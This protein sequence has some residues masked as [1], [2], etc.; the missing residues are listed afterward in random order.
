MASEDENTKTSNKSELAKACKA[1][2]DDINRRYPDKNPHVWRCPHMA[3]IAKLI[4]YRF[5]KEEKHD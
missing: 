4:G 5:E 2:C 1:L 3:K